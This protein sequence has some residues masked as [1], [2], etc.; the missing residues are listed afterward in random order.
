VQWKTNNDKD[1]TLAYVVSEISDGGYIITTTDLLS[2]N[3]AKRIG[4]I[5]SYG[6][7]KVALNGDCTKLRIQGYYKIWESPVKIG[8]GESDESIFLEKEE[9]GNISCGFYD[10]VVCWTYMNAGKIDYGV[11]TSSGGGFESS[12]FLEMQND[13]DFPAL[14]VNESQIA[15]LHS[16][17]K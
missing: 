13:P 6:G 12:T 7:N 14:Y 15:V 2:P 4:D 8:S 1:P 3:T 16:R 9:Y 17:A 10:D 5:E 11:K